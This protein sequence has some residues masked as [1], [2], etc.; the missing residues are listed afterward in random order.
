MC[1]SWCMVCGACGFCEIS[2]V[3]TLCLGV[4]ARCPTLEWVCWQNGALWL[5]DLEQGHRSAREKPD[6]QAARCAIVIR[7]S[8]GFLG[9]VG[10]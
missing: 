7:G 6:G 2:C 9:G 5:W 10:C 4:S 8:S 1:N 3:A